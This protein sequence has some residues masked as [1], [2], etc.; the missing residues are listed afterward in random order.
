MKRWALLPPLMLV[1]L[2]ALAATVS[3]T[4][5]PNVTDSTGAVTLPNGWRITP[6]G[7]HSRLPGDLPMKMAV[8]PGVNG[9]G[10]KLLV[11][12]A[13]YHDH[14][15]SVIDAHT[16][17]VT[18]TL[19][20]VKAWDGMAFDPASGMAYLSG[21]GPALRTFTDTI[22]RLGVTSPMKEFIGKPVEIRQISPA[23]GV[24]VDRTGGDERVTHT[25]RIV[26]KDEIQ[27]TPKYPS[28]NNLLT[29]VVA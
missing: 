15:L 5:L 25:F 14:S 23:V 26:T 7:K 29:S 22:A 27:P 3:R 12:T 11:L 18:A 20:V 16:G 8:I 2:L 17:E 21:G 24:V 9:E 10:S 1:C 19:D 28:T 13:G 4:R 6:A